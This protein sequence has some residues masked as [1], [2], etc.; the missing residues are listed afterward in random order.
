M[1]Y[2]RYDAF[3]AAHGV[4]LVGWPEIN[5]DGDPIMDLDKFKMIPQWQRLLEA[6]KKD[7]CRWVC[8][9]EDE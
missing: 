8:L 6:I 4:E 2:S 7:T 3:V 1:Q 9:S 5:A